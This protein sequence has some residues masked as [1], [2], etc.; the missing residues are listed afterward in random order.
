MFLYIYIY[1]YLDYIY[2]PDRESK[3]DLEP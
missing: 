3:I 1:F 2:I